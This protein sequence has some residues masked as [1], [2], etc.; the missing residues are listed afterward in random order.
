MPPRTGFGAALAAVEEEE[1]KAG[2]WEVTPSGM[3]VQKRDLDAAPPAAVVPTIR[4]K[5]KHGAVY[6]E[7]YI[8]SQ[9]TFGKLEANIR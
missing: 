6:H 3:V 8:S 7:I 4:V 2:E 5:V 1:K 9:A